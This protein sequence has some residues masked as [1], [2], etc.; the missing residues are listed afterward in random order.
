MTKAREIEILDA[1]AAQLGPHSYL[2][3]WLTDSRS[4]IV[5]DIANDV[6]IDVPMPGAARREALAILED[7]RR[8]AAQIVKDATEQATLLVEK[9][10]KD[11]SETRAYARRALEEAARRL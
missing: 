8:Q 3:P 7:A 5:A 10:R 9:A 4:S 2:G 6:C 1:T 11:A